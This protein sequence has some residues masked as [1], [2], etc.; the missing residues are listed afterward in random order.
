MRVT[1]LWYGGSSYA[2]PTL[3][4]AERFRSLKSAI[5]ACESRYDNDGGDTPC[6]NE[7]HESPA[8]V[9]QVWFGDEVGDYPDR[10]ILI[11]RKG[12]GRAVRC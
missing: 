5:H 3:D 10:E 8:S 9:A 11:S 4:D 12:Y 6:A 7:Y 2:A 1:I